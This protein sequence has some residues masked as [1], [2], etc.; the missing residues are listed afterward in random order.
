MSCV[1][2]GITLGIGLGLVG[3]ATDEVIFVTKTSISIVD[4]DTTP[5]SVSIAYDRFDGYIG[6]RYPDGAVPPIVASMNSSLDIF[7]PQISQVYATGEAAVLV[8][9]STMPSS[10]CS[11][12]PLQL[13]LGDTSQNKKTMYFGTS[14]TLGLKLG[15]SAQGAPNSIVLG[16]R[17]KEVSVIP[18]GIRTDSSKR[19]ETDSYPSV[20][21]S[22]NVRVNAANNSV[23]VPLTEYF[24]TGAA[25]TCLA[26]SEQVRQ[27]FQGITNSSTKGTEPS[28]DPALPLRQ[29]N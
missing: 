4:A 24:A 25:A 2:L 23:Q 10:K 6:P 26:Q 14:A 18:V 13:D 27:N 3:C 29:K 9:D 8:S 19:V 28:A 21:A 11:V 5:P 1:R 12:T 7:E 17:R 15:F 22:I 16:Y 20:I